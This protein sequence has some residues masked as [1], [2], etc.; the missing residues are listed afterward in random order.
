MR[1]A[2]VVVIVALGAC[3]DD[4]PARSRLTIERAYATDAGGDVDARA[5]GGDTRDGGDTNVE[6]DDGGDA[7]VR[8][9]DDVPALACDREARLAACDDP[10][11]APAPRPEDARDLLYYV[12]RAFVIPAAFPVSATSGW[13][14]CAGGSA[15]GG[16]SHDLVCLPSAYVTQP[17][18]LRSAAWDA[19]A[20]AI[21]TT[22]D[23]KPVG[24]EGRVGFKAAF[25][26]AFAEGGGELFAASC[27]RAYA[28]QEALFEGYVQAEMADGL[29]EDEAA[30]VA[31]T[32]SARPGHSEHQLGTT[33]DLVYRKDDG[34]ISSFG[35][36]VARQM[37]ESRP[38][39]WLFDNAHRFGLVLTYAHDR[40]DVTQYVWEPWH[41]RFV[42]VEA[43]DVMR[44]CMLDTEELLNA[45]YEAGPLPPYLGESLILWDDAT[46]VGGD[47]GTRA[48]DPGEVIT[49]T[50]RFENS[51]T[52]SFSD[53]LLAHVGG[54]DFGAGDVPVGCTPPLAVAEVALT[55]A[56]PTAPGLHE[57][58][59]RLVGDSGARWVDRDFTAR[60][61]VRD[62]SSAGDP[63]RFVRVD[64]LSNAVGTLDPGLDLD[65]I[66][67]ERAGMSPFFATRVAHYTTSSPVASDDPAEALGAPDVFDAFPDVQGC[68][69]SGG[70][71]SLGGAG[72]IVLELAEPILEGDVVHVLEVGA[73]D[74]GAG[75]AIA[76]A[77]RARVSVG[78]GLGGSWEP[79]GESA[80]GP[81]RFTVGFLPPRTR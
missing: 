53:M 66:V 33:C 40:V 43:A 22:S 51:G 70:F 45:R 44:R 20:P 15:P 60:V 26:A 71:V 29:E 52:W 37:Y 68:D 36:A 63:Y 58:R 74:Y 34:S 65:A 2:H 23:G 10:L 39:R 76:D 80:G 28:T 49:W 64:D 30:I 17:V 59:W 42:G 31:S 1:V 41:W 81:G 69:L 35:R 32:Y 57:G 62:G 47:A 14:P 7:E 54:E 3:A 8:P 75:T 48:V 6:R 21:T 56:A 11:L 12:N 46:I 24:H 67:V 73:C 18:S 55:L 61:Y 19:P 16:A 50:W 72:T 13:T 27:F 5:D 4:A 9:P 79:L 25:D 77:Y 38:M 78:D